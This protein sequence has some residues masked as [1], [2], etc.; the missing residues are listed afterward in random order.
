MIQPLRIKQRKLYLN[1]KYEPPIQNLNL[2]EKSARSGNMNDLESY[3]NEW[4][5]Y[6]KDNTLSLK[7]IL[8]VISG[9][10][11]NNNNECHKNKVVSLIENNIIPKVKDMKSGVYFINDCINENNLP[12][13]KLLIKCNE[14]FTYDRVI[15][16]QNIID[17]NCSIYQDE[18]E[19]VVYDICN[20][21]K[22]SNLNNN[23]KYTI[24]LENSLYTKFKLSMNSTINESDNDIKD[25]VDT[26]YSLFFNES[27]DYEKI[28]PISLNEKHDD[29]VGAFT[30]MILTGVLGGAHINSNI[31]ANRA[32]DRISYKNLKDYEKRYG[33]KPIES[34]DADTGKL[35]SLL[36]KND[37]D[38]I[39]E[40]EVITKNENGKNYKYV[41]FYNKSGLNR[42]YILYTRKGDNIAVPVLA[43]L[44]YSSPIVVHNNVISSKLE[45]TL[46][47]VKSMN[48]IKT[49]INNKAKSIKDE[50]LEL[51]LS[52]TKSVQKIKSIITRFYSRSDNSI[53]DD[54]PDIFMII[55]TACVVGSFSIHPYLGVITF[56][57]NYIMKL[58]VHRKQRDAV[59][60]KY[61]SEIKRIE[62]KIDGVKGKA[63]DNYKDYLKTLKDNK[64]KVDSYYDKY[65]TD[66]E[67]YSKDDDLDDDY[68]FDDFFDESA[69]MLVI[70]ELS[71][72]SKM[73]LAQQN[74]KKSIAKMSDKEKKLSSQMDHA[75]DKFVYQVEKTLSNKN[76]EAVIK[77]SLIPSLSSLIK[78]ASAAATVS[79]INPALSAITILGGIAAS[80]RATDNER[81][82]IL[83]EIGIQ[84][85]V[86]DKKLQLAESN[87]DMKSYEQLLRLQRQLESE[88]NRIVYKKRRP[89]VATA[90]NTIDTK[91]K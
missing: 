67:I 21:L 19:D 13:F 50:L 7:N 14:I 84:L 23:D 42:I 41:S 8:S 82:Y 73:K 2:L 16:N 26:F 76:R 54:L 64:L 55:R 3:I 51:D 48:K 12:S 44:E 70:N 89:V 74:F 77:G 9:F 65:F 90:Y 46:L 37:Y 11:K 71:F 81:K 5:S 53:I 47:E 79:F 33:L 63:K 78:L 83:D 45:N 18:I 25:I 35:I 31:T 49:K 57:T 43:P 10:M 28:N 4:C 66:D 36:A 1:S 20:L 32:L 87:N 80:K 40:T 60:S 17:E 72:T 15:N 56:V 24:A 22:E 59:I 69:D 85:N 6:N 62:K 52:D 86:I 88:K 61:D 34:V 30:G 39:I 27:L 29:M 58:H 91:K 38:D 68:D 75:Y